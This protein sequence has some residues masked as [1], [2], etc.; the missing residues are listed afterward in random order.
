MEFTKINNFKLGHNKLDNFN[1]NTPPSKKQKLSNN[2]ERSTSLTLRLN[3]LDDN[4]TKTPQS[5]QVNCY[6]NL[7][8][9]LGNLIDGTINDGVKVHTL[10]ANVRDLVRIYDKSSDLYTS[11]QREVRRGL[12]ALS[13][14]SFNHE[15]G[16]FIKNVVGIWNKVDNWM[17]CLYHSMINFS[18]KHFRGLL[19]TSSLI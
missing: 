13:P 9:F 19:D 6:R 17:V 12:A 15:R 8:Y 18:N 2:F 4:N 7:T 16:Q 11:I 3:A 10:Q 14:K 1:R 5:H